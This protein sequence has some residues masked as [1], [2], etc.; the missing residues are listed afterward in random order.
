[1]I[2]NIFDDICRRYFASDLTVDQFKAQMYEQ[3][4][5]KDGFGVEHY[6][7]DPLYDDVADNKSPIISAQ[8]F[9]QIVD[10]LDE[11]KQIYKSQGW[12][13]F[14]DPMTFIGDVQGVKLAGEPDMIAVDEN[15][16]LHLIDFKTV[17]VNRKWNDYN[18]DW[19]EIGRQ[20]IVN[21]L[22]GI[23]QGKEY[24]YEGQ[25][26]EMSRGDFYRGQLNV[27]A[28]MMDQ[29]FHGIPVVDMRLMFA[30]YHTKEWS[31][32]HKTQIALSHF[33]TLRDG[34]N[35]PFTHMIEA[36]TEIETKLR[37]YDDIKKAMAEFLQVYPEVDQI[38]SETHL[39]EILQ[40]TQQ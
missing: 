19:Y 29:I 30:S 3:I 16:G 7:K 6:I 24:S 22:Y 32:T 20:G 28:T 25:R 33:D 35:K 17:M 11:F 40:N 2:G 34:E 1:M 13:L 21:D 12:T 8:L 27:Y 15:G 4:T 18:A 38:A 39:Q 26:Q 37:T 5:Y 36:D 10:Q 14:T 31:P 23:P 9:D